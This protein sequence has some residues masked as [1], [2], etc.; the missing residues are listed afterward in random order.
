MPRIAGSAWRN[1]RILQGAQLP[2]GDRPVLWAALS[3]RELNSQAVRVPCESGFSREESNAVQGTGRRLN[4]ESPTGWAT[5]YVH[6]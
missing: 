3:R 2:V 5:R 1:A 6:G 4:R